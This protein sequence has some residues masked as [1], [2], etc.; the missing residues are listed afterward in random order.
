MLTMFFAALRDGRKGGAILAV[1]IC[2]SVVAVMPVILLVDAG[3]SWQMKEESEP[4]LLSDIL[5]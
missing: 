3:L 4:K 5:H 1:N 2:T